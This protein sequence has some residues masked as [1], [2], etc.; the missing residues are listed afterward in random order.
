MGVA[1]GVA[2]ARPLATDV[3]AF[4]HSLFLTLVPKT[5]LTLYVLLRFGLSSNA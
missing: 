3:A 1:N 5:V 2:V 4:R